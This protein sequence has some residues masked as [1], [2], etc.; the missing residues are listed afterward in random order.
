[1]LDEIYDTRYIRYHISKTIFPY[2]IK[3][4]TP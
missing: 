3:G 2:Y 1:M 4:G